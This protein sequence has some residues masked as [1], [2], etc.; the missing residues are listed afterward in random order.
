M[1][2][3]QATLRVPLWRWAAVAVM[4]LVICWLLVWL[5]S[6]SIGDL[7]RLRLE[8]LIGPVLGRLAAWRYQLRQ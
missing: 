6:H 5:L 4:E 7:D 3:T 2:P 8:L 1:G